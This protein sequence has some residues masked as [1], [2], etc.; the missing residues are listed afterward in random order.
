[1]ELQEVISM[2][3]TVRSFSEKPV[4]KEIIDLA[5]GA[6]LKAP[7]YNHLKQWDF[8]LVTRTISCGL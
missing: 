1:M 4:A 3:R 6:G 8:I 7:S 5:L 2:R